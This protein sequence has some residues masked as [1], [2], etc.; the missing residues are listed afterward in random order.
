MIA[1]KN[2]QDEIQKVNNSISQVLLKEKS[3]KT[4]NV[5][6]RNSNEIIINCFNEESSDKVVKALKDNLSSVIEV[7]KERLANPKMKLVGVNNFED[8]SNDEIEED[9]NSR[10]FANYQSRCTILHSYKNPVS[11]SQTF[12]LEVPN[13]VYKVIRL[14]N[15]KLFIGV[16]CCKLYDIVESKPCYKC[17]RFNHKA[18]KCENDDCCLKC[19]GEH[20]TKNCNLKNKSKCANC[21]YSNE[22]YNTKHK[23]DHLAN[24]SKEC[25]IFKTKI[26]KYIN[27]V[28]YPIEPIIPRFHGKVDFDNINNRVEKRTSLSKKGNDKDNSSRQVLN[29]EQPE[30]IKNKSK[31]ASKNDLP[32]K[33]ATRSK[34]KTDGNNGE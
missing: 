28:D 33:P 26:R 32:S 21:F 23:T 7:E 31:K 13:E 24:D 11:K 17:G 30:I 5:S 29:H 10:N 20:L 15:S 6:I 27:S 25:Q 19:S 34:Q 2:E 8:L 14:N 9:I 3:I 4:K 18:S 12:I 16:Q 1:K 22:N